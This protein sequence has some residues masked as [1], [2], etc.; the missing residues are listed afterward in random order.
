MHRVGSQGP[1]ALWYRPASC[2]AGLP[3][4][5]EATVPERVGHGDKHQTGARGHGGSVAR[6]WEQRRF[7]CAWE[8]PSW[9]H[10]WGTARV[11]GA[12]LGGGWAG[13]SVPRGPG[14]QLPGRWLV[15]EVCGSLPGSRL[16]S[17]GCDGPGKGR[18]VGWALPRPASRA[19]RGPE[20]SALLAGE[21][22]CWGPGR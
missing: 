15:G 21:Q 13:C 3:S 19:P 8:R 1:G 20:E 18:P 11:Q 4:C 2:P 12:E 17:S 9:G 10:G 6:S 14:G 5:G 22:W 16:G 7:Q